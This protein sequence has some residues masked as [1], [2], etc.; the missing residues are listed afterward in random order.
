MSICNELIRQMGG[1]I[2]MKSDAAAGTMIWISVPCKCS[3]IV[4]KP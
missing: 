4:R 1:K 2:R 3:E